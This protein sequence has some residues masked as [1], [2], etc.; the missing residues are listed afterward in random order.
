MALLLP[1][2]GFRRWAPKG[3]TGEELKEHANCEP[4]HALGAVR[5]GSSCRRNP[6]RYFSRHAGHLGRKS[7]TLKLNDVTAKEITLLAE[8]YLDQHREQ[9]RAEAEDAIATWPGFERWRLPVSTT[10]SA[11]TA[12]DLTR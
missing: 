6:P 12:I 10:N 11:K 5:T 9:L 8:D 1:S 2:L 4:D 7:R 3:R